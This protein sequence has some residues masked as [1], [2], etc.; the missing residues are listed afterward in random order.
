[1]AES[2]QGDQLNFYLEKTNEEEKCEE[3]CIKITKISK[4][5]LKVKI[6]AKSIVVLKIK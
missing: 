5:A 6:P 4:K 3:Y 1:M 2:H